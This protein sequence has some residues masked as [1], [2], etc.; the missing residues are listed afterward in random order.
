MIHAH[1]EDK[2][3]QWFPLV[4][5]TIVKTYHNIVAKRTA[6]NATTPIQTDLNKF[7]A[8]KIANVELVIQHLRAPVTLDLVLVKNK[9]DLISSAWAEHD[10]V[11]IPEEQ[12]KTWHESI[13]QS[14]LV[15]KLTALF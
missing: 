11:K 9:K 14:Y 8:K 7:S 4:A 6:R 1:F 5:Q 3:Q 15:K 2:D 10:K 12:L 13:H